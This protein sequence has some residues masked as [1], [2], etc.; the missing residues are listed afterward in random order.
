MKRSEI[1][2]SNMLRPAAN[3]RSVE[4]MD[5]SGKVILKIGQ[6]GNYISLNL[7]DQPKGIYFFAVHSGNSFLVKKII[8][9]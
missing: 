3:L 6:I 5:I 1:R 8:L 7:S 4:V 2:R 9:L